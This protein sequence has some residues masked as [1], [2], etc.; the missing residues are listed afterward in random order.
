MI[1]GKGQLSDQ[2]Q[3]REYREQFYATVRKASSQQSPRDSEAGLE[4]IPEYSEDIYPYATFHLPD[5]E[6]QSGNPNR[7]GCLYDSRENTL[8]IIRPSTGS[9]GCTP[10]SLLGGNSGGSG[11]PNLGVGSGGGGNSGNSVNSGGGSGGVLGV[12]IGIGAG[13]NSTGSNSGGVNSINGGASSGGVGGNSGG[14]GC[15]SNTGTEKRNRRK[16]KAI[17]SESEEYDSLN[18]D[19]DMSGGV[20]S[21]T[22]S[23][24]HLDDSAT[25]SFASKL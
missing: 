5:H 11:G 9:G 18:S 16:S 6:N 4:R 1:D 25:T 7:K 2:Q 12:S 21:R 22:E 14:G 8:K 20:N 23:S 24:S 10:N 17:K 19:S 3:Q 15:N 13:S